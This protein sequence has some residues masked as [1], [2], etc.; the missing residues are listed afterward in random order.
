MILEGPSPGGVGHY[1]IANEGPSPG[2]G[3]YTIANEGP[4]P[5]VGHNSI[6]SPGIGHSSVEGNNSQSG[7]NPDDGTQNR[8]RRQPFVRTPLGIS[9]I[10]AALLFLFYLFVMYL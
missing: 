3:H 1:T 5:G 10:V 8:H 7:P 9:L 6:P 2:V 4:S